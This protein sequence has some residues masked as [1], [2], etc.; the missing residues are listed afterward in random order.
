[1]AC[2]E[3]QLV[4]LAQRRKHPL[5]STKPCQN[6][7]RERDRGNFQAPRTT[8]PSLFFASMAKKRDVRV[9]QETICSRQNAWLDKS[10]TVA[11]E[12]PVVG[13]SWTPGKPFAKLPLRSRHGAGHS[14]RHRRG[15]DANY[16]YRTEVWLVFTTKAKQARASDLTCSRFRPR[17]LCA[18]SSPGRGG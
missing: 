9:P 10:S 16:A 17:C 3:P 12:K 4:L 13:L 2:L 6:G 18:A 11:E 15:F 1:M 8:T 7:Q 5:R 14:D